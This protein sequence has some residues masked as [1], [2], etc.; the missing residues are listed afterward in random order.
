MQG[1]IYGYVRVSTKDQNIERQIIALK[2]FGVCEK[3]IFIDKKSGKDFQRPAYKKLL[4][5]LKPN[6]ILIVQS[7]DRLGRNYGEII[8]QWRVI[9]K[10]KKADIV[11][12]DMPL[13]DT[14]QHK[15]LIGSLITDIILNLLSYFVQIEREMNRQRQAEGISAAKKRGV[16]FGR[17]AK[18]IPENFSEV[19]QLWQQ[20]KISARTAGK[21]LGTT[22]NTF[23]NWTKKFSRKKNNS[24]TDCRKL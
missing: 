7:I 3:N 5:N 12:L 6:D 1:N 24:A 14:R 8:E 21:M 20:G 15:D 18:Q 2:N 23:L 9:T 17:P 10:G 4:K 22:H 19:Y 13:L 11:I 16:K